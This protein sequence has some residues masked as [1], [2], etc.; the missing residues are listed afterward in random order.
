MG[1]YGLYGF[2]LKEYNGVTPRHPRHRVRICRKTLES[3]GIG[4]WARASQADLARVLW[5]PPGAGP[6]RPLEQVNSLW[7]SAQPVVVPGDA[8]F[9]I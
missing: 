3:G 5:T 6:Y 7:R 1:G 2:H 8:E 9:A 4:R